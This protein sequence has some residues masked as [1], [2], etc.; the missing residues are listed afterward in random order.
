MGLTVDLHQHAIT[1]TLRELPAPPVACHRIAPAAHH[2]DGA[3]E[4]LDGALGI[5]L[6][7]AL[8]MGRLD[9]VAVRLLDRLA[10]L[11]V[12]IAP[13]MV[14]DRAHID[15]ADLELLLGR[16]AAGA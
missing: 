11:V 13:A 16:R 10:A 2:Q 15:E 12:L 4:L 14:A 5:G 3:V 7:H 8:H 9:L 6:R 1:G